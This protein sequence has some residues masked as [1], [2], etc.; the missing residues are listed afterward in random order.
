MEDRRRRVGNLRV[1][2]GSI[3]QLAAKPGL[4]SCIC[5]ALKKRQ[6][7][8]WKLRQKLVRLISQKHT[9]LDMAQSGYAK[10]RRFPGA[11]RLHEESPYP[12]QVV[13]QM[14]VPGSQIASLDPNLCIDLCQCAQWRHRLRHIWISRITSG[15]VWKHLARK[16]KQQKCFVHPSGLLR[17]SYAVVDPQS[18]KCNLES[19]RVKLLVPRQVITHRLYPKM[20]TVTDRSK[21]EQSVGASLSSGH[22]ISRFLKKSHEFPEFPGSLC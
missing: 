22:E 13:V 19:K 5:S 1:A 15:C 9:W 7:S 12:G 3:K 18:W 21:N 2:D 20:L 4:E 14:E 11:A 16:T 8:V 6:D 10:V 17:L